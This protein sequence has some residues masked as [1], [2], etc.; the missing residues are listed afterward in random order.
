VKALALRGFA[1]RSAAR[2]I[3]R[4]WGVF[5]L[6]A[7]L[8]AV[9]LTLPAAVGLLALQLAP[10]AQR[11]QWAPEATVFLSLAATPPQVQQVRQ[12]VERGA[13]VAAVLLVSREA[14][15][16]EL[17]QRAGGEGLRPAVNPLPDALVVRFAAGVAPQTVE[18]AIAAIRKLPQVDLVQADTDWYRKLTAL[19]RSGL[20]LGGALGGL[21]LVLLA[22]TLAGAARLLAVASVA[23]IRTL[24]LLGASERLIRR[25]LVYA[26]IASMLLAALLAA[27]LLWALVT[28][29]E[30]QLAELA[31]EYDIHLEWLLPSV[32]WLGAG[33]AGLLLMAWL[34]ASL[35]ARLAI[36]HAR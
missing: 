1:L 7:A 32:Q 22:L 5:L 3:G 21:G 33:L 19:A 11:A 10:L 8:A 34:L 29:I 25:P 15:L 18:E 20:L 24:R 26:G 30:P 31:T 17:L 2:L 9:A 23:E 13:G 6:S 27:A 4:G 35:A 14:A 12:Q 36:R 16:T 28:V